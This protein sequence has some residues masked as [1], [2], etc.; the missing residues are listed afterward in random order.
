[1]ALGHKL[2]VGFSPMLKWTAVLVFAW[3]AAA[4]K[5]P[6]FIA[7]GD[8]FVCGPAL[9]NLNQKAEV[10]YARGWEDVWDITAVA[11]APDGMIYGLRP[12][13]EIVRVLP[14]G[15]T[16]PFFAGVP[17]GHAHGIAVARD[18]R[19]LVTVNTSR[20]SYLAVISPAGDLDALH[21]LPVSVDHTTL[22]IAT[23]GC[24]VYYTGGLWWMSTAIKRIDACTGGWLP[25]LAPV[26]S[27]SD[28]EVLPN[29]DLLVATGGRDV[30]LYDRAGVLLRVPIRLAK[31]FV[32]QLAFAKGVVW[33]SV[34][35]SGYCY[36]EL[37]RVVLSSGSET[38][39]RW[40]IAMPIVNSIVVS[41]ATEPPPARRRSAGH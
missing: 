26:A 33:M 34:P 22:A 16:E 14:D 5:V 11:A 24:T 40:P 27:V 20:Q 15:S 39:E 3:A 30:L 2:I 35:R 37:V 4:Q 17:N 23:D 41:D 21:Q 25:D 6:E 7:A 38:G 18:G 29:G 31:G 8:H 9:V 12:S 1:M 10:H 13:S 19:I 28:I 32:E 36:C